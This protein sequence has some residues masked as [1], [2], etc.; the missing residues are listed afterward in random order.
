MS[1]IDRVFARLGGGQG[2]PATEHETRRIPRKGRSQGA[3]VVEVVRLQGR[4]TS[5]GQDQQPRRDIT[6]RAASWEDGFPAKP[7]NSAPA[8]EAMK[9]AQE[10]AQ[11]IGHVI[12]PKWLLA[13][14]AET[15]GVGASRTPRQ[16][17]TS[18]PPRK[19]TASAGR[20]IADPLDPDDDGANCM[21][22]G[23][24]VEPERER[25]GLMICARCG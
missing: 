11:V 2:V 5:L 20:R 16:A 12:E 13:R 9:P 23:Y 6:V 24:L 25:R 1:D 7:S 15:S 21:R 14:E 8:A 3:H 4:G 19:S 22:C 18:R 17:K 10:P